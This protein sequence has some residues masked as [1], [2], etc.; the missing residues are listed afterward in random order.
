L[1]DDELKAVWNAWEGSFGDIVK[2]LLLRAQRLW[3]DV[4]DGVSA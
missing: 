1:D 4:K 3:A 2:L